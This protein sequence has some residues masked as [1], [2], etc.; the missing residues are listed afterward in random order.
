MAKA[1][2]TRAERLRMRLVT[3]LGMVIGLQLLFCGDFHQ[4]PPVPA[5]KVSTS[6]G[7]PAARMSRSS[8]TSARA[9]RFSM[10]A[11]SP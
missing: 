10:R 1:R 11:S 2:Q 7:M 8:V 9:Q 4:L 3:L 6:S 5:S